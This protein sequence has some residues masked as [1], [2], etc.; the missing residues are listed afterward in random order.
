MST[1]PPDPTPYGTPPPGA[2]P[3]PPPGY[4]GPEVPQG[5]VTTQLA[6]FW[7][8]FFAYL[9]DSILVGIVSGVIFGVINGIVRSASDTQTLSSGSA[10]IGL[11]IGLAYFG[12]L[13]GTRGQTLGY[14][15]LGIRVTRSDGS[16]ITVGR[17]LIRYLA[18]YLSGALCLIPL[19]IS[20]FMIGLGQRKQG[21][22]DL[23]A[24]T[25]VVRTG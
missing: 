24:D 20:A 8:R 15:V 21:I 16:P 13:W 25:V 1:Q 12:W 9:I 18:L 7:R 22:H 6:G 17:A 11:V 4:P 19:I 2:P 23:I 10:L 3:P 5:Y 14:M